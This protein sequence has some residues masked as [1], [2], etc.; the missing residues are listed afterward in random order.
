MSSSEK[1]QEGKDSTIL[2]YGPPTNS[3]DSEEIYDLARQVTA[4]SGQTCMAGENYN[5]F[6][7][8]TDP[9]LNPYSKHFS[10]RTWLKHVMNI[11]A[12]DSKRPPALTAGV[13][14]R[15]LGAYGFGT[16]TDYQKTVGNV[17][18]E[19]ITIARKL[20]GQHAKMRIQILNEFDGLVRCGETC[21]VLGRPGSGCTTLLKTIASDTHG[22]WINDDSMLNYQG[23]PSNQ[24]KKHFRGEFIYNAEVDTHFPH[25]TVGDTLK[26]AALARTPRNRIFGVSREEFAV[27]VRDVVMASFGLMHTMNTK[28]GD[29]FVR[30]VSGGERKRVSLAEA[31]L[32]GS[33]LQCWD[34]STRGLDAA[35]ALEFIKNLKLS[36]ENAGTACFVSLYQASQSAYDLFDKVTVLYEGRQ[37]YFGRADKAKE[38]FI[39]MG[40]ICA[41]RQT[42]GDFLTSL[43]NPAE[44]IV[45]PG[46]E[47]R[48]PRTAEE[49]ERA[50]HDSQEYRDLIAEIEEYNREYPIGGKTFEEFKEGRN[51]MKAKHVSDRSP[52]TISFGMQVRLC[53]HRGFLRL[54]G[55]LSMA[56]TTVFGNSIMALIIS[57]LF[58]DMQPSTSSFYSRG[59][60]LFFAILINAFSSALEILTLYAQRPI[61]EKHT[62]Y[63]LYRPSAE[64]VSSMIVDMPTKIVTA[65]FFNLVLYFMSNLRRE[66]GAFFI[67]FLFSF[68]AMLTMSM[69]FRTIGAC[70]RTISQA[71]TPAS[72][73]I[74]ALVIYTGF[75]IPISYMHGWIRWFNY[76]NPIAY[77]FEALMINEFR[78]RKFE[79]DQF[80]PSGPSYNSVADDN[81][82]CMVSGYSAPLGATEIEGTDYIIKTFQYIPSHIWRNFGILCG[83]IVF[84]CFTYLLATE[85]IQASKSKGEV[86]VF[87]RGKIPF[88]DQKHD[89]EAGG[90][91]EPVRTHERGADVTGTVNLAKQD[92]IFQWLDVC[93]DI[94]VKG[95]EKTRRLLDHVDGWVKPGTLTA[96]VGASGAGKTTLLDALANRVTMGVVTGDMLVNGEMR[97]KSFQ[98]K[99][100][101]VQQQDLHLSTST[102]R[103]ALEFSALLRQPQSVSR[104]EKIA[105]VDEVIKI[106]E[107]ENYADAVVGVPG[108]GL[109]VEQRKRLTIGVELAARPELL[110]FFDEPTSG[111]DSQTA[112][113]ICALMRKLANNGQAILCTI[114]QPS[115]ILFQEFDRLL[116]LQKGGQ[117]VYFGDIG[118]NSETLV[119]Y[120]ERNGAHPCPKDGNPAEWMLEVVGAA[121]GS[122]AIHD[123][124]EVWAN[125]PER[126]MLRE[127]LHQM[128]DELRQANKNDGEKSLRGFATGFTTQVAIVT[129]RVWQQY[130]RTP[131]Y[132]WSKLALVTLSPLF[133]GFSFYKATNDMQGLQNQMFAFFMLLTIFGNMVQQ[134]MPHFVT[135][136]SLYEVRERPS[137]T[138]SWQAFMISNI[139]TEIPWQTI[140]A[141]ISYFVLYYP[142]G[143]Y[144]NAEYTNSVH[145]RGALFFLLI[146]QFYIFTST[147][148]HMVIAGV[149]LAETGGNIAQMLFSLTLIMCGVLVTPKAMPGFW[150]F[151]YRVSPLT[152]VVAAFLVTGVAHA[153][154]VCSEK[155]LLN[156]NPLEGTTCGEYL[157]DYI[158]MAGG[159]LVDGN[160]TEACQFC[161]VDNTD[162]FLAQLDINPNW[163]WRNFGILWA[164]IVFNVFAALGLYWLARVPKGSLFKRKK[165]Q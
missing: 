145:E 103:E 108:E 104:E 56:A 122:V 26:F 127:E 51:T 91:A 98:R 83:F 140:S 62:R 47:K 50:W 46:Y 8:S 128:A 63:A 164:Y 28:V 85:K 21:V 159:K 39:Q 15:K 55:D 76:L 119:S 31:T 67:F 81:R 97:N 9:H 3:S 57:S 125:S 90:S 106:L 70:S 77:G 20:T 155:E 4:A 152:Y 137:K 71:M 123:W 153:P 118:K 23:I 89:T 84:F 121:P 33:V 95:P 7:D 45:A 78:N 134:I 18:L 99:T 120:F 129:Q 75:T 49:F 88:A 66:P 19:A 80:V 65:I 53:M 6:I 25:L 59:A 158:S 111:L 165:N 29:D 30:G 138:Y 130:W 124:Y 1:I 101:Y 16:A 43:T 35:T 54:K 143:L 100:G 126:K 79:C 87:K 163:G 17:V 14:F 64:A 136:R 41:E 154:V 112:W 82:A 13:A 74:L 40:F 2:P 148:S 38:F 105:Y 42:T 96:L 61:V 10:S 115:A 142:I 24:I 37:I 58:F 146:W 139:I 12:R 27:H 92:G 151:M 113:S 162:Q 36:A 144:R 133:I 156:F 60:L 150:I 161:P 11:T 68:V 149:S 160:A 69:V 141:V 22:F 32:N 94:P 93:Y 52:Y 110:L 48:V 5:P 147:L 135:Q 114:H 72:I 132:I 102:V 157:K 109:N 117:T 34:N 131:E 44:R 73:F 107:M 86:L 116:F